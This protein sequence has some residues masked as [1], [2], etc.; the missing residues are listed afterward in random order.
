MV[1]HANASQVGSGL[2]QRLW[3]RAFIVGN[4]KEWRER[5]V[6][7]VLDTH[8]ED[9][10]IRYGIGFSIYGHH[11]VA[12]TGTHSYTGPG[13]WMKYFLPQITSNGF[14]KQ[15]YE[16]IVNETVLASVKR[17]RGYGL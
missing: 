4:H 12:I 8:V 10:A 13:G 11:N 2:R 6:Y 3:A 7:V 16:A 15:S 9:T 14:E 5:F 1:G 17:A